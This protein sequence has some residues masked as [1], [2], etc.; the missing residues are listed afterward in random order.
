MNANRIANGS[1]GGLAA[2]EAVRLAPRQVAKDVTLWPLVPDRVEVA[3]ADGPELWP[4]D[5]ALEDGF[6]SVERRGGLV[7]LASRAPAAIWVPAGEPLGGAGRAAATRWI[8]PRAS[9]DVRALPGDPPCQRCARGLARGFHAVEGQ[10]GFVLA[11]HE[12]AVGVELVL[13]PGLLARRLARRIEAWAPRLLAA[14]DG[15]DD[16]TPGPGFDSPEALLAAVRT[17]RGLSGRARAELVLG[18]AGIALT[19]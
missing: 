9:V 8:P 14:F 3:A 6:V 18:P 13:P 12:R 10:V 16:A 4:L 15:A 17:G 7:R 11:V 1:C 19:L 5:E 2:L